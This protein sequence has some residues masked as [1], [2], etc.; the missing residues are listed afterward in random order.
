MLLS[1]ISLAAADPLLT[2]AQLGPVPVTAI[3]DEVFWSH[4]TLTPILQ[5]PDGLALAAADFDVLAGTLQLQLSAEL[6]HAAV[7][8]WS[9]SYLQVADAAVPVTFIPLLPS[10]TLQVRKDTYGYTFAAPARRHAAPRHTAI[11]SGGH[12]RG[13]LTRTDGQALIARPQPDEPSPAVVL[14]LLDGR[15]ITILAGVAID[16]DIVSAHCTDLEQRRGEGWLNLLGSAVLTS[17]LSFTSLRI[18]AQE[19]E[20]LDTTVPTL[21]TAGLLALTGSA[22]VTTGVM[23]VKVGRVYRDYAAQCAP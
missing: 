16:P 15:T 7:I 11:P 3:S 9:A 20:L 1:L 12:L 21:P 17:G 19:Q 6:G 13:T 14:S 23:G 10:P 8:D 22:A 18:Y 5:A 4:I 2:G